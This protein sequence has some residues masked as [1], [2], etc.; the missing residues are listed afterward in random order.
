MTTSVVATAETMTR[1][2]KIARLPRTVRDE[3]NRRL[4]EGE[5]GTRLVTW[6]N[7][8][9]AVQAVLKEA[10]GGRPISEQ[11]L[12]EW[13]QGGF[14]DWRRHQESLEVAGRMLEEA[15]D[16]E[17]LAEGGALADRLAETAALALGQL[18]RTTRDMD[19]GPEKK[20]ATLEIVR[21]LIQLRRSDRAY[22]QAQREAERHERKTED[23]WHERKREIERPIEA[24]VGWMKFLFAG[25]KRMKADYEARGEPVAVAMTE[26]LASEER[27]RADFARWIERCE[28]GAA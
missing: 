21:E 11:N 5:P 7:D 15:E 20:R 8:Q 2:G 25:A 18:L 13:K 1:T 28:R 27:F 4:H 6:L 22:E 26:F 14:E 24:Y 17:H 19:D 16:Y 10:F 23:Y 12:S 9:E 3:L